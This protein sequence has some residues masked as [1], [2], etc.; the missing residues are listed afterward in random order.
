M[1]MESQ[2]DRVS[3][4]PP[5]GGF[6]VSRQMSPDGVVEQGELNVTQGRLEW[7]GVRTSHRGVVEEPTAIEVVPGRGLAGDHYIPRRSGGREVTLIQHEHLEEIAR[8]CGLPEVCPTQ[9]RR[10]LVISGVSFPIATG[11]RIVISGVELEVTG[12]C[13]PCSRMD[14]A[15]GPGGCRSMKGKGGITS[16]IL[17]GGVIRVGDLVEISRLPVPTGKAGHG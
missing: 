4:L 14:E 16:R 2:T 10:N 11:S 5:R 9:L 7:I 12:L 13:V 15:L 17:R 8:T 6:R 1:D 3:L